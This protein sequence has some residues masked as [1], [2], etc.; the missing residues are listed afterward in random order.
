[1]FA[2]EVNKAFRIQENVGALPTKPDRLISN[3]W[4]ILRAPWQRIIPVTLSAPLLI[5]FSAPRGYIDPLLSQLCL[6]F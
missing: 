1:M 5:Q 4:C 2:P 6:W 3:L